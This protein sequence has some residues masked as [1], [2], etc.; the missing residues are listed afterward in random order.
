MGW[1]LWTCFL[2]S[3]FASAW[4]L[5]SIQIVSRANV[6]RIPLTRA[7]NRQARH[8]SRAEWEWSLWAS[9]PGERMTWTDTATDTYP[10]TMSLDSFDAMNTMD[11]WCLTYFTKKTLLFL[12]WKKKVK[13]DQKK[14]QEE[15][16]TDRYRMDGT[17][18]CTT[19]LCFVF[20]F[21]SSFALVLGR[22]SVN[23]G[24]FWVTT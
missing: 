22:G 12:R 1:P 6:H 7:P 20:L 5:G 18:C 3:L 4:P 10:V 8:K 13:A 17:T 11:W 2:N 15:S 14:K 19:G 21:C 23:M 16:V 9:C 24:V